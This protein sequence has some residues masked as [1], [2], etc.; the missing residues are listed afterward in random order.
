MITSATTAPTNPRPLAASRTTAEARRLAEVARAVGLGD[1]PDSAIEFNREAL[2]LL[3]SDE[4]TPLL[5]D[6]LRWQGSVLRERGQTTQAEQLY[7]HSLQIAVRLRYE[8]GRAHALN[9]L[10]VIAQRRGDLAAA[11]ELYEEA[12]RLAEQCGETRLRAMVEQNRGITYDIRGEVE[13]ALVHYERSLAEFNATRDSHG[14]M[15]VLNNLGVLHTRERRHHE[16]GIALDQALGIARDRGDLQSEAVVEENRA[17]LF[18]TIGDLPRARASA[19]RSLQLA[20]LRGD[21][22]RRAAALKLRGTILRQEG[23]VAG[24]IESLRTALALS[25][26]GED[27]LLGAEVL[28]ELGCACAADGDDAMSREMWGIALDAFR[29]IGSR[30]WIERVRKRL[31]GAVQP[32]RL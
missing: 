15:W 18:L 9:C 17:E 16:A 19:T 25:A 12:G 24:A 6:V 26:V 22:V 31:T 1:S 4:D 20:E 32:P 21:G 30:P 23:D 27:A 10:A 3:G 2:A 7:Q 14:K 8:A 5:A 28:Y 29:R 13:R 11:D